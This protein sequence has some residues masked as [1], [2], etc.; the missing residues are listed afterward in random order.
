MKKKEVWYF[1]IIN[2]ADNNK[3]EV[4]PNYDS[5]EEAYN[6]RER[7]GKSWLFYEFS[8]ITHGWEKK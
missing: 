4:S 7:L 1:L 3:V 6:E 8:P 2:K 5:F